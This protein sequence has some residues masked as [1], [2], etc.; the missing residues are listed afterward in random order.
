MIDIKFIRNN[1]DLVREA[2]KNKNE[3]ADI[4]A[5]LAIDESRRKLQY[6]FDNRRLIQ[7]LAL[8]FHRHGIPVNPICGSGDGLREAAG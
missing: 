6:D 1:P 3:K 7:D 4:N 5:L 8:I 2:I